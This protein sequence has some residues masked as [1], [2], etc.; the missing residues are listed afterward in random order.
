[1]NWGCER[2]RHRRIHYEE[3]NSPIPAGPFKGFVDLADVISDEHFI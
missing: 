3:T 2:K 1:M